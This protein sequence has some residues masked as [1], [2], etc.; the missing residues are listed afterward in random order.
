M[1]KA[2]D[3]YTPA[4]R[5]IIKRMVVDYTPEQRAKL[6]LYTPEQRDKLQQPLR[7]RVVPPPSARK[8]KPVRVKKPPG[9]IRK[10]YRPYEKPIKDIARQLW[11]SETPPSDLSKTEIVK[12]VGDAYQKAHT[13]FVPRNTILRALGLLER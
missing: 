8:P 1:G 13:A 4:Q 5:A 7:P 6:Q 9:K 2:G 11:G 12:Q 3:D 10:T